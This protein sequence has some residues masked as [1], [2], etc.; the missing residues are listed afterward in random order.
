M[1]YAMVAY[2][3]MSDKVG[4]LS[5]YD[6]TGQS[7]MSFT[8]PYSELTAQGIDA[9]TKRIIDE[10]YAMARKVLTEHAEGLKQLAELLLTREVVFTEDVERIFGKRKKDLL[11]ERTEAEAEERRKQAGELRREERAEEKKEGESGQTRDAGTDAPAAG[12]TVITVS[13]DPEI[14]AAAQE[15][16]KPEEKAGE[17]PDTSKEEL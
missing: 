1:A 2:Y 14:K 12:G 3:G 11:R 16:R 17:A 13:L 8:K 6:S 9:E 5:Y 15:G 4:T 10:A 7:D